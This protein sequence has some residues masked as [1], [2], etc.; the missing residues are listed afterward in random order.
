MTSS[1]EGGMKAPM[2]VRMKVTTLK[3]ATRLERLPE[4]GLQTE[5]LTFSQLHF[6]LNHRSARYI[7]RGHDATQ[8]AA[9]RYGR[10]LS[11]VVCFVEFAIGP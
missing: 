5:R 7:F 2:K 4:S 11:R 8:G 9:G 6:H 3:A 10:I 1:R